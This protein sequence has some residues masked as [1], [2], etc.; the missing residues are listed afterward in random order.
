M[1]I[2]L[3]PIIISTEEALENILANDRATVLYIENRLYR[4]APALFTQILREHGYAPAGQ[5]KKQGVLFLKTTGP[6][7]FDPGLHEI[8]DPYDIL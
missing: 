3:L 6:Y 2:K 8:H 5:V 7:R 1:P 4:K